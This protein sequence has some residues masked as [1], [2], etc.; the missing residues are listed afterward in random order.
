MELRSHGRFGYSPITQRP[1]FDWPN[2]RR[3]AVYVA[4]NLEHFSFG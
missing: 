2:G 1:A 4:L 3:L